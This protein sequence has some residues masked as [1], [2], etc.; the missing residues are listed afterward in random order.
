WGNSFCFERAKRLAQIKHECK[1]EENGDRRR[2]GGKKNPKCSCYGEDCEDQ[3]RNEPTTL[4]SLECPGCGRECRKYKK[5]ID[6]KK[7][8]F[9]KQKSAYEQQ[10]TDATSDNGNK[11]DSNFVKKLKQYASIDLLLQNLGACS[12]NNDNNKEDKLDFNNPEQTFRPATNCK[13]CPEFKINCKNV[14]C[15]DANGKE[16]KSKDSIGPTDIGN[17]RNSAEDI[18]ML[19][20]DSG[21]KE[22]EGNLQACQD[23][24]IFEGIREDKWK[25]R[26]VCGYVVC[27]P[28]NGNGENVSGENNDQIITIR[29][30]V[31]HWVHNFLEDYNR[32]RKKLKACMKNGKGSTCTSDC[33]KKW[34]EKKRVEWGKITQRLN[35]QYKN[36]NQPDY[37][38]KTILEE[39][40]PQIPV[41]NA[42]NKVIKLSKFDKSKGCCVKTNSTNGKDE[43]AINCMIKNLE[44]KIQECNLVQASDATPIQCQESPPLPEDYEEEDPEN[45]VAHPKICGDIEEQKEKEEG[46]CKAASPVVPEQPAKEDGGTAQEP[47]SPADSPPAGP[48]TEP[49]SETKSEKEVPVEPPSTPPRPRPLPSDNTSDILKTT[50][51]FG[52][53]LAL[54]S[55]ALLFL[56]CYKLHYIFSTCIYNMIIFINRCITISFISDNININIKI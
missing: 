14:H 9:D 15:S 35:E 37:S 43:D 16:C 36:D 24:C 2:G 34:V 56:K 6:I 50:I 10:K 26:N 17:G 25:C 52:I 32:I 13:P 44:T 19:V 18:G 12:K 27:K 48:A 38:V 45:K 47:A 28:E 51:P 29:G 39:L 11:Y 5:W 7:K 23:K 53:A 55:I 4:H 1:V 22:F 33:V 40:I 30:L 49:Q 54:T 41:A 8:E 46:D 20:S 3:L 31:E 21:K 42:K